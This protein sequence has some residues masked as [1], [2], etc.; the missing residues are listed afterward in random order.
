MLTQVYVALIAFLLVAFQAFQ[1]RA[2][3][4]SLTLLRLIQ[5]NF[6]ERTNLTTLFRGGG[7]RSEDRATRLPA[8]PQLVLL[9]C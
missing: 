8:D 6:F 4:S 1:Q 9:G 7:G 5:L 2:R 3:A